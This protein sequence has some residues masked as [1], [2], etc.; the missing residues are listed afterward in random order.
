MEQANLETRFVRLIEQQPIQIDQQLPAWARRSNPIIRRQL[1]MYWKTILPE[2]GL[3]TRL[4]LVQ[5]VLVAVSLPLPF[6]FNL[7][8]PAITA[9]VLLFPFVLYLYGQTLIAIGSMAAI[10]MVDEIRCDTLNL[11]RATPFSLTSIFASKIAA[12][13]WRQ[14]ENLSLLIFAVAVFSLPI[15]ISQYATL[16]P[17]DQHPLL[18]RVG[19]ILGLVVS[20]LRLLLEP[21]MIGALGVM[22]G[23]ALPVR[24]SAVITTLILAGFY[25]LFL[26]L[27]RLL[28]LSWPVR[29]ISEF[30]LPLVLPILITWGAFKIAL[31]L[32][33]RN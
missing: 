25:F 2:T 14:V 16:W 7:A 22:V 21:A 26:N 13:I 32:V 20:V 11:L 28:P 27:V 24:Y 4:I 17:I 8:L 12:C 30:G 19:M 31:Y 33:Q 1:G 3:L 18:S 23:V 15:L 10:A 6:I 5:V 29:F 9:S